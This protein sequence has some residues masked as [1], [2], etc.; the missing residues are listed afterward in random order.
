[1]FTVVRQRKRIAIYCN[2]FSPTQH[3]PNTINTMNRNATQP[4]NCAI[5]YASPVDIAIG[6][7]FTEIEFL[8]VTTNQLI[9]KMKPASCLYPPTLANEMMDVIPEPEPPTYIERKLLNIKLKL[10]AHRLLI[11][12]T[13]KNCRL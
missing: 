4:A 8:E 7:I 6:D 9:E 12:D 13:I 11:E 5:E 3:Q 2:Q 1:M 10:Q